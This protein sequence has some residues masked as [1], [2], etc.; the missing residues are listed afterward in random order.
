STPKLM[1][2]FW[3]ASSWRVTWVRPGPK[4][5]RLSVRWK[6]MKAPDGGWDGRCGGP[7]RRIKVLVDPHEKNR[8]FFAPHPDQEPK[9]MRTLCQCGAGRIGLI[10][11]AN[12]AAHPGA[13]LRYVVDVNQP[14]AEALA[15]KHGAKVTTADAALADPAVKAV[16]IASSTDTHAD[17]IER[18]AK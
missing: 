9:F 4:P 8:D 16:L 18:A 13:E 7:V 2:V 14:A 10:H 12:I 6:V 15:A 1:P 5:A 17:L 11:A 3:L